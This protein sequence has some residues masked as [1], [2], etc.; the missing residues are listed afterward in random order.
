MSGN[1]RFQKKLYLR[2][3]SQPMRNFFSRCTAILLLAVFSACLVPNEFVHALYGHE[4]THENPCSANEQTIGIQHIHCD[5][6]SYEASLYTAASLTICPVSFDRA[7]QFISAEALHAGI[8]FTY[9][10]SLRGPPAS[11]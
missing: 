4:D 11:V 7:F 1:Y 6:L 9:Y 10:P 8:T 3:C 5:F 2:T